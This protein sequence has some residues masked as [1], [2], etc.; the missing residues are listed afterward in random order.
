MYD[1]D[2]LLDSTDLP[3]LADELLGHRTGSDR[4]PT[5]PCPNPNHAQTGATPPVTVFTGRNGFQRWHCHGCGDGGTAIDLVIAV[6]RCNVKDA[7]ETLAR[8]AGQAGDARA[9]CRARHRPTRP[10]PPPDRVT[11]AD[12]LARY[13]DECAERLW[14]PAG[15]PVLRWLTENR[16][17]PPDVLR[18]N[19][20]GADPGARAQARPDGMPSAGRAA[21]LPV[22][23]DGEPVFAQLRTITPGRLRYVNA[24]T[25]LAP[26][27]RIGIYEPAEQRADCIIVAEGVLD[28]LSSAAAGYRSA[29]VLGAAI[30]RPERL[31]ADRVA[32]T[33]AAPDAHLVLAFDADEAGQRGADQLRE[34]L[35]ARTRVPTTTL[36]LPPTANDL[37]DWMRSSP[38]WPL[39]LH[40][41]VRLALETQTPSRALTR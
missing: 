15:E 26:N 34:L 35:A 33:L 36:R 8:R 28:A 39:D 11:D 31:A 2:R 7:L 4:S 19:R 30:P 22:L 5:W 20:I 1:R 17:L 32:E 29:A 13:V 23:R 3:A 6:D 21:V 9:P 14:T 18:I 12:G 38:D 16:G 37:N 41:F 27:P 25:D 10:P 24:S 40:D